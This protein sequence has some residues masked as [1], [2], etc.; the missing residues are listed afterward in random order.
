MIRRFLLAAVAALLVFAPST[1][2]AYWPYL[3]YGGGNPWGYNYTFNSSVGYVPPPPYYA[4]FPPVY[5]S[6]HIQARHYGASPFAWYAG[7]EPIT[8]INQGYVVATPEPV[9]IENPYL[10]QPAPAPAEQAKSE[11]Q[12]L[13]ID[14]PH[15]ARVVR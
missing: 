14:N 13:K 2:S 12:P 6:P 15:V 10:A 9:M 8:F 4:V 1:A 11:V 3:G 7:M 5:Y